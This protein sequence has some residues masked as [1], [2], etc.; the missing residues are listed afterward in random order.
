MSSK[1]PDRE[2]VLNHV[3]RYCEYVGNLGET[4]FNV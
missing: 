4:G 2:S 3:D 1:D